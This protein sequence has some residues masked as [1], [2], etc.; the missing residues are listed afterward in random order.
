MARDVVPSCPFVCLPTKFRPEVLRCECN[1]LHPPRSPANPYL[2]QY[3]QIS[4]YQDL[5]LP[6]DTQPPNWDSNS[7]IQSV[8]TRPSEFLLGPSLSVCIESSPSH[9]HPQAYADV[10]HVPL[11]VNEFLVKLRYGHDTSSCSPL[12]CSHIAGPMSLLWTS[13]AEGTPDPDHCSRDKPQARAME[14][15]Q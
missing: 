8:L 9:S 1:S 5:M 13:C 3:I 11:S 7:E 12:L 2:D 14:G 4:T 6:E 15:R 10:T